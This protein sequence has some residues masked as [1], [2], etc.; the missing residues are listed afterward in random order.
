MEHIAVTKDLLH[1]IQKSPTSYN[2]VE[3]ITTRLQNEGFVAFDKA[4]PSLHP[5]GKYYVT[6]NQSSIIAFKIPC[7][8][9]TSLMI[10]ASHT[11]SPSFKLKT[12]FEQ[13]S[14]PNYIRL[15]VERYGGMILSSWLDRPLSLA[16][17]VVVQDDEK[18]YSKNVV[19]NSDLFIIPNVAIHLNRA[20]NE[21]FSY[22]PAV[23]L[24]PLFAS[25]DGKGKLLKLIANEI[26]VSP[27]QI[28]S[29]DLF[30][31]NR[32]PG[33]LFGHNC[34][35]FSSPRIDNLQCT[36]ATLQGFIESSSENTLAVF[37]SFDNE[38]TGST[39]KQGAA[40][41]FL[42]H[43]IEQIAQA[44]NFDLKDIMKQSLMMSADNAH[45]IHPNHPEFSDPSNAPKMNSGIVIKYNANQKYTTDAIS[46]S[47][48]RFICKK[49]NIPT[50][51]YANRS[52]LA[53]GSTLGSISNTK[54]SLNT[55]D[56]GLAQLS[57]HSSYETAGSLDTQYLIQASKCFFETEI[58][59]NGDGNYT[60]K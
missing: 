50:Q 8:S 2:T 35:F 7:Y 19:F 5:G 46:D 13:T 38:E 30:L 53:G 29:H 11:D 39:T 20:I 45:A 59:C 32:T 9:P 27:E 42:L 41:D 57:M 31:Y 37:C 52:D 54:L 14:S 22:N 36:Y 18:I 33:M 24:L 60:I 17:R 16:G 55:I 58:E 56:I 12:N 6:R 34:E 21:G 15:N 49:A 10:A 51:V 43:T 23:D 3:S 28:L 47:M 40:S 26:N 44:L 48:F 1:F 4:L 25:A